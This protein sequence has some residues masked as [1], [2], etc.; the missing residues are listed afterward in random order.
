MLSPTNAVLDRVVV[1]QG[2]IGP[3]PLGAT[4]PLI[5]V[6]RAEREAAAYLPSSPPA[7]HWHQS[8]AP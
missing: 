1:D 2:Q 8:Q 6:K 4:G 3:A 5:I 7:A